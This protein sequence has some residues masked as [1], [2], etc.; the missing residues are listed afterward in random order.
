MQAA[1]VCFT[2]PLP[3]KGTKTLVPRRSS[4]PLRTLISPRAVA[5]T[6]FETSTIDYSSSIS[7]FPMEACDII[8]GEA[9][10]AKMFPEAKLAV[11]SSGAKST[12]ALQEIDRDYIEYNEPK[13]VFPGE[14]CDDLGGEFCE[15]EYLMGV[16]REEALA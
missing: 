10:N 7:V 12:A 5:V 9:C 13:T 4:K 16:Y 2:G 11:S 14:A 1:A 15:A 3:V 6:T 8:G